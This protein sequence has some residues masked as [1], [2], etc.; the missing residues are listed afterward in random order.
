MHEILGDTQLLQSLPRHVS[1][2][3]ARDRLQYAAGIQRDDH[4]PYLIRQRHRRVLQ[5]RALP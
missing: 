4:V 3:L 2:V 5:Q 1:V